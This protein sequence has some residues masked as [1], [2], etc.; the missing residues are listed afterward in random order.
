MYEGEWVNGSPSCGEYRE[1]TKE[2]EIRFR[3]PSIARQCFE[4][5]QLGLLDS[6]SIMDIAKTETRIV[7]A[8]RRGLDVAP[9][10]GAESLGAIISKECI[11]RAAI[12]FAALDINGGGL[13][14]LSALKPVFHELGSDFSDSNIEAIRLE[15]EIEMDTSL[16]FPETVDIATYLVSNTQQESDLG[17]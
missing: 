4:L 17:L 6:Q 9:T 12:T 8:A 1:P 14:P 5:P 10:A 2:E 3:E 15:L 11:S 16:S 7:N 13:L